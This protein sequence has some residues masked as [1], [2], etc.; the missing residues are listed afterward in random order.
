MGR[1]YLSCELPRV[2]CQPGA[3]L[4]H[5]ARIKK[6]IVKVIARY[7][8]R[9][10]PAGTRPE[11]VVHDSLDGASAAAASHAAAE[12]AVNLSGCTCL[13]LDSHYHAPHVF[14]A[15]HTT[16]TDDHGSKAS[17]QGRAGRQSQRKMGR[18]ATA[19][20]SDLASLLRQVLQL[21]TLGIPAA[22]S[23]SINAT[24]E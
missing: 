1:S 21:I 9:R 24:P 4:E 7:G 15:Q 19:S 3:A 23:G 22:P 11:C 14:I 8:A 17:H 18:V 10:A 5:L 6:Y 2:S 20:S 16:G 13:L 12:A